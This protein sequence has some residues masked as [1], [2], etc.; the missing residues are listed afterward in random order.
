MLRGLVVVLPFFLGG[1]TG[2]L[3][4]LTGAGGGMIASPLLILIMHQSVN[5]ASPVSLLAV[6]VGAGL[7]AWMGLRQGIVRYRAALLLSLLGLMTSPLGIGLARIIPNAPML[8]AFALVLIYQGWR[9]WKPPNQGQDR[10]SPCSLDPITGRF[11]WNASCFQA[12]VRMG[13]TTGFL[14]GLLGVGG[15]FVLVPALRRHTPLSMHSVTATSLMVLTIVSLGGVLQ[16]AVVGDVDWSLTWPFLG[17]V[18]M[19][20]YV[21]RSQAHHI[22]EIYMRRLFSLLCFGVATSLW[23]K[24]IYLHG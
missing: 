2:L 19:G 10:D 11:V 15:G 22:S 9:Y 14:S 23:F 20:I 8:L 4:G 7:G 1:L 18:L 5:E 17:G 6:S 13:A 12:M 24:V 3:L 16:W 21:G